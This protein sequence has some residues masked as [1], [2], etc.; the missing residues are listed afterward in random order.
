MKILF[1]G[2]GNTPSTFIKRRINAL[3]RE[4]VQC[5][6][7]RENAVSVKTLIALIFSKPS[8]FFFILKI[9]S[10]IKN[11]SLKVKIST[12]IKYVDYIKNRPDIIH[13][14]WISHVASFEWLI[15]YFEVP[16]VASVRGSMVTIYPNNNPQYLKTLQKSFGLSDYIHCVSNSLRD[17]CIQNYNVDADKVFTNYNGIDTDRFI[18][19][20]SIEKNEDFNLITVGSLIWRKGVLFQLLVLKALSDLPIKL[21]VIGA[22]ED[23]FKLRYQLKVLEIEDK[24]VFLGNKSEIEV[25]QKLQEADVYVSTSIAEGLSNSVLEAAA[26]GLPVVAFECEGMHEVIKN[27]ETGY[28][29]PF[30]DVHAMSNCIRSLYNDRNTLSRLG[31]KARNHVVSNFDI[32]D[33][34]N[35]MIHLYTNF[36]ES[37]G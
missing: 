35:K 9:I 3:R 18:P 8:R 23:E 26:I 7:P 24:V 6:S 5:Y 30:S 37:D 28:I 11:K 27:N 14:Q 12:A 15:N 21:F 25:I 36:L 33:H 20:T 34:V 2:N 22:G 16:V 1:V 19:S 17:V 4:G 31:E 29:V 13:F 32:K 10:L